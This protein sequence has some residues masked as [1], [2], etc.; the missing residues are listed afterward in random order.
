MI[1][2]G[3]RAAL[4]VSV[5]PAA[6]ASLVWAG[7]REPKA[8][9]EAEP[10]RSSVPASPTSPGSRL[11]SRSFVL[12]TASY[13][14]QGYVGYIF[15]FWFYLYLVQERGFTLLE[16]AFLSSLPWILSIVS[17]PFGGWLS[18]RLVGGRAGRWRLGPPRLIPIWRQCTWR[19]RPRRYSVW[20]DRSGRR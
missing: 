4:L 16:G 5:I 15:V 6:A 11:R 14:L 20:K 18:D 3:W 1:R 9:N 10:V 2:W 13:T 8:V 12:L 17:I 7:I 19:A